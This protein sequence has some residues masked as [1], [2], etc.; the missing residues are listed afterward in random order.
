MF[1]DVEGPIR[2][3][4]GLGFAKNMAAWREQ[5]AALHPEHRA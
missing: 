4:T 1:A 3:S 2:K 5:A